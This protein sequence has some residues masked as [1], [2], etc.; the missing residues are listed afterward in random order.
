MFGRSKSQPPTADQIER[1]TD[2]MVPGAMPETLQIEE[3]TGVI[4]LALERLQAVQESSTNALEAA[5]RRLR[6]ETQ[7][8]T[9]LARSFTDP[10]PA[11]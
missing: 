11:K 9:M 2:S 4:D 5:T 10:P 7:R 3:V 6:A 8:C 1:V